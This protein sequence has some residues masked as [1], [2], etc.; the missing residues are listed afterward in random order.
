MAG[1]IHFWKMSPAQYRALTKRDQQAMFR[2]M[3]RYFEARRRASRGSGRAG[4]VRRR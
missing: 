2:W 4:R 3:D 1:F